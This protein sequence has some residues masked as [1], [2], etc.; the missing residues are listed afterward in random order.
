MQIDA[1][2]PLPNGGGGYP[3]L[4]ALGELPS[5]H[6]I[7]VASIQMRD[8]VGAGLLTK[9]ERA[10]LPCVAKVVQNNRPDA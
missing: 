5:L 10:F 3:F 2:W 8:V 4:A 1:G 9:A 7:C 6:D